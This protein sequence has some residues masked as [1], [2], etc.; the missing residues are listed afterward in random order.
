MSRPFTWLVWEFVNSNAAATA[1]QN[2]RTLPAH[3][4]FPP[5]AVPS[6]QD[7]LLHNPNAS[8]SA[9]NKEIHNEWGGVA[10]SGSV[11]APLAPVVTPRPAPN[12]PSR[13]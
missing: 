13:P 4:P 1:Y 12:W 5:P 6:H 8:A 2:N 3:W 9:I 11:T 10:A 7:D